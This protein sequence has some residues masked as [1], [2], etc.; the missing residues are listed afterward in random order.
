MK[1]KREGRLAGL[2]Q[3]RYA[4]S[5]KTKTLRS[6]EDDAFDSILDQCQFGT[7]LP[8]SFGNWMFIKKPTQLRWSSFKTAEEM[9]RLCVG[10]HE[11]LPSEGSEVCGLA[12]GPQ[13][14]RQILLLERWACK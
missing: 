2:E 5:W 12:F 11:R 9:T 8:D 4:F 14:R 13:L 1:Q 3:S 7:M 10:N 6:L